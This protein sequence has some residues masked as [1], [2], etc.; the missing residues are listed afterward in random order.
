MNVLWRI[1]GTYQFDF[2]AVTT[3]PNGDYFT[4][5]SSDG[6]LYYVWYDLDAGSVDPAPAGRTAIEVDIVTGDSPSSIASKTATAIDANA[7]FSASATGA[8]VD[9]K[10][11]TVGRPA[12]DPANVDVTGLTVTVCR[13]GQNLDLGLLEGDVEFSVSPSNFILTSHQSGVTPRAALFQGFETLECT[14]TMQETVNSKLKE[15]YGLYG[16][17]GFTPD[18]SEVFSG[19][20]NKQGDNLLIDAARLVL[21]PVN[22][23]DDTENTSLMMAIPIPDSLVFSGENPKTLSITWQGFVDDSKDSKASAYVFGDETQ[24]SLDA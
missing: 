23:T 15:I 13:R 11:A 9:V 17:T 24:P 6:D 20:T 16:S 2:T 21:K 3:E 7:D 18:T 22:A 1:E 8:L 5:D 4:I 12:S 10:Q 14:T 19:G